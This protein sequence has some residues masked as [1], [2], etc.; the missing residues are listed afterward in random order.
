MSSSSLTTQ[1]LQ[2]DAYKILV[3]MLQNDDNLFW[4]RNDVL[5]AI[6]GGMLT[7]IGLMQ[8]SQ[9]PAYTESSKAISVVICG[10]GVVVCIFWLLIAKRSEAFYNHWVEQLKFLEKEYLTPIN[11][12]QIADEFFAKGQIKLGKDFFKLDFLS[13]MRMFRAMQF[14]ALVFSFVWLGLGLYLFFHI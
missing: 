13:R 9:A 10:I 5:I 6:N 2:M 8:S 11:T 12:F 4:R 7:V 1:E 14:L 3:S